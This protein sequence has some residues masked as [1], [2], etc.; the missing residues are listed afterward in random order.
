L[1][2]DG[3]FTLRDV[4]EGEYRLALSP[5][6]DGYYM[7]SSRDTGDV[8]VLVSHGHAAP[9]EVRL[10]PGAGRISGTVYKDK[11]NQQAAPSAAI[12]L[13][14]DAARRSNSE[15]YRIANADRSGNFVLGSISPGDYSLL[16][17]EEVERGAYMDPDFLQRYEA[18]A[19]PIHVEEGGSLN[20][21]LQLASQTQDA[22]Q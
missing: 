3:S 5:L 4:V 10:S 1:Q 9:V 2:T 11:D 13:I 8:V 12:V 14:P 22:S 18:A 6:P 20:L 7:K 15:Y 19:K 21:Q 16:A 17:L